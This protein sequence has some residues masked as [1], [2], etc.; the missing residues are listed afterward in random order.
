MRL[1][2]DKPERDEVKRDEVKK[3]ISMAAV[4]KVYQRDVALI[5]HQYV[6]WREVSM[7]PAGRAVQVHQAVCVL[8]VAHVRVQIDVSPRPAGWS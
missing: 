8:Q 4:T 3:H 6:G 1:W 2:Q 7:Q 5:S